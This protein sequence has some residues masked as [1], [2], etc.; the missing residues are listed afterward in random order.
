VWPGY[1]AL[2]PG[3]YQLT[4]RLLTRSPLVSPAVAVP[5]PHPAAT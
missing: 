3:N 5:V 1:G 2:P 4:A